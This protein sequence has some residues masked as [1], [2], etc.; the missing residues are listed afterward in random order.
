VKTVQMTV[1]MS[2]TRPDGSFW[3]PPH[4]DFEMADWEAE[5]HIRAGTAVEAGDRTP[6]SQQ[7]GFGQGQSDPEPD[8]QEEGQPAGQEA[9]QPEGQDSPD[10]PVPAGQGTGDEGQEPGQEESLPGPL[11]VPQPADPKQLWVDYAISQGV[12]PA[13][14]AAWTKQRLQAEF[15]GRL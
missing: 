11:P 8:G 7:P 3:P 14:A 10:N 12:D 1:P 4:T 2:G 9:G 13:M 15:G 5:H 6:P